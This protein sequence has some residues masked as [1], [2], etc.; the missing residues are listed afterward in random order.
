MKVGVR[1]W[2]LDEEV[3]GREESFE[4]GESASKFEGLSWFGS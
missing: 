2:L 1:C 3:G 4:L